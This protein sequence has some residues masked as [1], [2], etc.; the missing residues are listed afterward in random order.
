MSESIIKINDLAVQYNTDNGVVYAVNGVSL[1]VEK[2][3]TL[4]LVGETG[5]GK[6]TIARSIL[7]ILPV[8]PAEVK[9]GSIEFEGRELTALSE[10]EMESYVSCMTEPVT[11]SVFIRILMYLPPEVWEEINTVAVGAIP[12]VPLTVRMFLQSIRLTAAVLS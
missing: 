5:A 9:S 7:R 3:K 2:G 10:K 8:P 4:G 1:E 12:D 6:T 11:R